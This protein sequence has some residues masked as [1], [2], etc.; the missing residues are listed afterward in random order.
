MRVKPRSLRMGQ[1]T[2]DRVL[3]LHFLSNFWAGYEKPWFG[4]KISKALSACFRRGP[5]LPGSTVTGCDHRCT[6]AG[7]CRGMLLVR[8]PA[9][10]RLLLCASIPCAS[11]SP[12][13]IRAMGSRRAGLATQVFQ[14]LTGLSVQRRV[15]LA[16]TL[17]M[18]VCTSKDVCVRVHEHP[19]RTHQCSRIDR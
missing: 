3:G 15:E 17:H 19:L 1:M 16:T 2:T 8:A 10:G 11:S 6:R 18:L 13:L 7:Q 14:R 9:S 5:D 4:T 12:R